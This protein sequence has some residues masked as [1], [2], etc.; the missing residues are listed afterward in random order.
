MEYAESFGE[1]YETKAKPRSVI[2]KTTYT[3]PS[4]TIKKGPVV[5]YPETLTNFTVLDMSFSVKAN[6]LHQEF[7]LHG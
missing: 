4:M 7:A 3:Y 6:F 5:S 2:I 1:K